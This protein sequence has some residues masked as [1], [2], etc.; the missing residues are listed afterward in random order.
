MGAAIWSA[1]PARMRDFP[2]R[3]LVRFFHNHGMLSVDDRPQ[4]RVIRGGSRRYLDRL[5]APWRERLRL[6]SPVRALRRFPGHVE[7]VTDAGGTER[8]D[9]AFVACHSDQ[10]LALLADPRPVEREVLGA[11]GYQPNEAVLHTDASV[12]PRRRLAWAAWNYLVPARPQGRVAVTYDMNILQ[13][14][15]APETFC[16]T[17]NPADAIDPARVLQ[18]M[19]YHHPV[20]TPAAVAA[21]ARRA[22]VSGVARTFYCGA[23]WRNGFHED[24]VWSGERVLARL[25]AE[26]R[27]DLRGVRMPD[28][29]TTMSRFSIMSSMRSV[30][31]TSV[32]MVRRSRL[33][34]PSSV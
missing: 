10:A 19:T 27:A 1:D 31:A 12:L 28:S 26:D 22:E 14:L 8:H 11:I 25:G 18:R 5:M 30:W 21:Q 32:V 17:L 23:Y 29:L 16:V 24:G 7:V 33:L 6:R 3:F 15:D 34:M 20:F 2:A 9:C 13:G 4:W